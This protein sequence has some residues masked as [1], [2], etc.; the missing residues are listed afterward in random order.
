MTTTRMPALFLGHGSPMNTIEANRN[1]AAWARIGRDYPRPKAILSISAHWYTRSTAVTAMAQPKTIHD[2]GGFPQALFD[3]QYPAPGDAALAARV[4]DLLAPL[5]VAIDTSEWGLDHGTWSVLAHVYPKADIPVV[6]LSIDGTQPAQFH[7]DLG[8]QLAPLRDEGILIFGT[9]NVVHNLGVMQRG[10]SVGYDWAARFNTFA[11]DA[12]T[13]R[14]DRALVDF[15]SQ[16][17]DAQLAIPTPEHY[18]PLLYVLGAA[19]TD[20]VT[21]ENDG[22]EMGS[23]SMLSASFGAAQASAVSHST[24]A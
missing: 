16:G 11:R 9:G 13:T 23:I 4:R 20:A 21:I 24:A 7:Y 1:T 19:G 6:Q 3:F 14:H 22:L 10:G 18:L 2:F 8:K 15:A 17:R 5:P 12:L